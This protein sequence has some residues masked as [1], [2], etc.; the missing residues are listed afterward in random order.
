MT[1]PPRLGLDTKLSVNDGVT[2]IAYAGLPTPITP[3]HSAYGSRPS[4][5]RSWSDVPCS[6]DSSGLHSYPTTPVHSFTNKWPDDDQSTECPACH[7]HFEQTKDLVAHFKHGLCSTISRRSSL[8]ALHQNSS[9]L[10]T[11]HGCGQYQP[12]LGVDMLMGEAPEFTEPVSK[13]RGLKEQSIHLQ[14]LGDGHSEHHNQQLHTEV[15]SSN[16]GIASR[17]VHQ[18]IPGDGLS[19]QGF[20]TS[21]ASGLASP[22]SY[23]Q[24]HHQS[25]TDSNVHLRTRQPPTAAWHRPLRTTDV[26]AEQPAYFGSDLFPTLQQM[27]SEPPFDENSHHHYEGTLSGFNDNINGSAYGTNFHAVHASLYQHSQV[28]VPSQVS[29]HDVYNPTAFQECSDLEHQVD[30]FPSSFASSSGFLESSL[31]IGPPSPL[32]AYLDYSDEG[33]YHA[34]KEATELNDSRRHRATRAS[35]CSS[36]SRKRC[37]KR[38]R[39]SERKTWHSHQTAGIEVQCAGE[40]F[41]LNGPTKHHTRKSKKVHVCNHIKSNGSVCEA[42][43]ER[44]EHLKRHQGSHTP[45]RNYPCPVEKCVQKNI[46]IQRPDNAGDHFKTHLR[47]TKPGKR[48]VQVQWPELRA[49]ILEMYAANE[50]SR[51]RAKKLID[52]LQSWFDSGMSDISTRQRREHKL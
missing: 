47:P 41:P 24:T 33:E 15:S 42:A 10:S 21:S 13:I 1:T 6:A 25:V 18:H 22:A 30:T 48:N 9:L 43:F 14:L 38:S 46:A 52:N 19:I 39:T 17:D 2:A 31:L 45:K 50:K 12:N 37:S 51:L 20:A 29:P 16:V 44:S 5:M 49:G 4:S 40:Q 36:M 11:E 23:E 35:T 7:S 8:G 28:I 32:C 3:P 27:T 26:F 34:P